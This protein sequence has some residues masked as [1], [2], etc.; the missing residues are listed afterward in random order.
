LHLIYIY[1]VSLSLSHRLPSLRTL[2]NLMSNNSDAN[3]CT[4]I[5]GITITPFR[6]LHGLVLIDLTP[7]YLMVTKYSHAQGNLIHTR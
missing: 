2:G 3:R 1:T 7:L 4:W 6:A 5:G